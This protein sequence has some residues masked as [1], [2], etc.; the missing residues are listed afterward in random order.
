MTMEGR[1][2]H[3]T[4]LLINVMAVIFVLGACILYFINPILMFVFIVIWLIIIVSF[5]TNNSLYKASTEVIEFKIYCFAK[6]I[7]NIEDITSIDIHPYEVHSRYG[8]SHRVMLTIDTEYKKYKFNNVLNV[9]TAIDNMFLENPKA[10]RPD[11]ALTT[12]YY[13]ITDI[14][15][16]LKA[17]NKINEFEDDDNFNELI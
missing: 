9:K 6:Y 14:R 5:D 4:E 1:F 8:T 12:L 17:E 16:E 11:E 13:Y 7:I 10:E 3:L 2:C 15:E